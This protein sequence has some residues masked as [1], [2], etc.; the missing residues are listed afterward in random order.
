MGWLP[1]P[2]SFGLAGRH[3]PDAYWP[4]ADSAWTYRH[5]KCLL[6][7]PLVQ[8][9]GGLGLWLSVLALVLLQPMCL[10]SD[11]H[12]EGTAGHSLGRKGECSS[13]VRGTDLFHSWH[14]RASPF[15]IIL[16]R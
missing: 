9:M 15:S 8:G 13:E 16:W 1:Q 12:D 10:D 2:A 3:R 14:I 11:L 5:P 4:A 6:L 7:G